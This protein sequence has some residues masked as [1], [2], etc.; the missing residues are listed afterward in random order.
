MVYQMDGLSLS[1]ASFRSQAL[2][3]LVV[4]WEQ[5]EEWSISDEDRY[6]CDSHERIQG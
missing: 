4:G 1:I 3:A 2:L 6:D 5:R